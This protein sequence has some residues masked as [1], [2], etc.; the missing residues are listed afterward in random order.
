MRINRTQKLIY[1]GLCI[2]I[3]L[4]L[5]QFV[6]IIPVS[7]PGAILLPMHITVLLCGFICGWPYG[8]FCGLILPLLASV[9]TGK[10]P[11]FPTG[12]SMMFELGAYGAL[13]GV[14]YLYTKGKIYPSLIGAMLGGRIVMGV[15]NTILFSFTDKA[16]GMAV[17]ITGAFVTALPGIIIQIILIP[18][19]VNNLKKSKLITLNIG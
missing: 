16:Y 7:N 13:T 5:P 11:L 4:I 3:G 12:I 19:I 9:L 1:T 2:G 8:A 10:P 15:V 18:I 17:F 6:K 14:I